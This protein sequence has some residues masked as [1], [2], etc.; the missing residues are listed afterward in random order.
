MDASNLPSNLQDMISAM[1]T[2]GVEQAAAI[3]KQTGEEAKLS[4]DEARRLKIMSALYS[5]YEFVRIRSL[6]VKGRVYYRQKPDDIS[7]DGVYKELTPLESMKMVRNACEAVYGGFILSAKKVEEICATIELD[8]RREVESLDN[9]IIRIGRNMYWDLERSE[10]LEHQSHECM[11]ELFDAHP[12]DDLKVNINDVT[13]VYVKGI[14]KTMLAHLEEN[15]GRL[16]PKELSGDKKASDLLSLE[17]LALKPFWVWANED[18]DTLN[19]L[20]KSVA[21]N[22]MAN[23]PKGAFILIGR[24]RN[25]KSSFIKMLHTMF[26]RRNTSAVKLA[27]LSS[28]RL[29]MT[30]RSSFLNAPDEED[31]G[32]KT[33]IMRSQSFFKSISAHEP[34]LLEVMYSQEPQLVSTQFMSYYPMNQLPEWSGTGAEACMRRS[35]ILMFNNDLSK[36]DNNGKNFEK[37]TYTADFYSELLGIVLAI[38]HYYR[39]KDISFSD[40]LKANQMA[41]ANEVDNISVYLKNFFDYFTG[42]QNTNIIWEDYKLWCDEHGFTYQNKQALKNKLAMYPSTRTKLT[43]DD[44]SQVNATRLSSVKGDNSKIF[45]AYLRLPELGNQLVSTIMTDDSSKQRVARSVVGLMTVSA[46]TYHEQV[47]MGL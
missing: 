9:R 6:G 20:L 17:S 14:Y 18:L 29:N 36:Y 32:K 10:L 16:I 45:H 38:A 33:E 19:D 46:D 25:G 39:D 3:Q 47:Y 37:E 12:M 24:T 21:T 15:G 23:K 22:F 28:P 1:V 44:G 4:K 41:V 5:K 8:V 42:Y 43:L 40:T 7:E 26:G 13:D 11:R 27:D 31:E 34:I 35:L 30:L 2:K